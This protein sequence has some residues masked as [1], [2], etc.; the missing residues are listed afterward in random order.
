MSIPEKLITTTENVPE[1]YESGK[2]SMIDES[3]LLPTT[4][5][6]SYI[7]LDDVSEVPHEIKCKISGVD[8][9]ENVNVTRAGRNLWSLTVD[10]YLQS[11]DVVGNGT[12]AYLKLKPNTQYTM[13]SN[14][15][16]IGAESDIWFN[17]T[18]TG[19]DTVNAEKS[20]TKTTDENGY[21]FIALRSSLFEE[22]FANDWFQ[23]VEGSVALPYEPADVKIITPN[24]DGTVVGITSISP[25]MNIFTDS[26][27]A[28]IEVT[29]NKSWGMQH[30]CDKFWYR[31][32]HNRDNSPRTNYRYAF[33]SMTED[34]F[35][36]RYDIKPQG[37]AVFMFAYGSFGD[38]AARMEECN[39]TLDTSGVTA[40]G[41]WISY[42]DGITRLPTIDTRSSSDGGLACFAYGAQGLV[43]IDKLILKDDGS[44]IFYANTFER[45]SKL[46][47][48]TIEGSIGTGV[49]DFRWCPLTKA[50]VI[51]VVNALSPTVSGLTATFNKTAKEAQVRQ[52]KR[53][54]S[55][56][57]VR[58]FCR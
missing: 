14:H 36:P 56:R 43:T 32:Q 13:S 12:R 48:I 33:I 20:C 8:N 22:M 52:T 5:S 17:G 27:D 38:I 58:S 42:T 16:Q 47:D 3:K 11:T 2:K 37:S 34:M 6:G 23:I 57:K 9:L 46:K 25:Y 55:N 18:S 1:V 40:F 10:D 26:K 49:V 28:N 24:A 19:V 15:V 29:Y 30:E 54:C 44:Q 45:C 41:E 35:Y 31:L 50:S 21:L 51:S 53:L 4:V 7:S 39:V